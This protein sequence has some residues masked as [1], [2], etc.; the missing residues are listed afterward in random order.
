MI[1][2]FKQCEPTISKPALEKYVIIFAGVGTWVDVICYVANEEGAVGSRSSSVTAHSD[3]SQSSL[4]IRLCI[5]SYWIAQVQITFM[6]K[7]INGIY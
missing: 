2:Q 1:G 3:W 4:S 5:F 7:L 6:N